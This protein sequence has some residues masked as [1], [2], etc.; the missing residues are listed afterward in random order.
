MTT[1]AFAPVKLCTK[2]QTV[3]PIE[4]FYRNQ[5]RP[6]GRDSYC[7]ECRLGVQKSPTV[8]GQ[9]RAISARHRARHPERERARQIANRAIRSG[10]LT[11][12]PCQ[13]NGCG[14][15]DVQA[16]HPDYSKP[17]EVVWL[18]REHHTEHHYSLNHEV[19]EEAVA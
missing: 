1:A 15:L 4:N 14:V 3:L 10:T 6:D 12:G 7:S 19:L 17:L 18:C 13:F 5:G 11:K 2:C 9:L 16:H 8:M